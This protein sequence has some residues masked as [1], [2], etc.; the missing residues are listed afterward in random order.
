MMNSRLSKNLV[1]AAR[2]AFD[3]AVQLPSVSNPLPSTERRLSDR[4]WSARCSEM[5]VRQVG[6]W[7]AAVT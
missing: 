1:S 5:V 7:R 4:D 3:Q 6:V 2:R